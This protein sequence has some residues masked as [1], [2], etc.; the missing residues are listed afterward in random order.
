MDR[1]SKGKHLPHL[2]P[3]KRTTTRPLSSLSSLF[4]I[5]V[6]KFIK[7]STIKIIKVS[8]HIYLALSTTRSTYYTL[9]TDGAVDRRESPIPARD[10]QLDTAENI[11]YQ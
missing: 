5:I 1:L 6:I 7:T 4:I 3:V 2:P 10:I 8:S 9:L 11:H